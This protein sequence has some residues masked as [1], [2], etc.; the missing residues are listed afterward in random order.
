MIAKGACSQAHSQD[1]GLHGLVFEGTQAL[2]AA[3]LY[4][5]ACV[6]FGFWRSG[7]KLA[8][9]SAMELA[10]KLL[11]AVDGAWSEAGNLDR[12]LQQ[13]VWKALHAL[14]TR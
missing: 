3:K 6:C 11:A 13:V 12:C 1:R 2:A 10:A 5:A 9:Q 4:L 8:M 14:G 7:G